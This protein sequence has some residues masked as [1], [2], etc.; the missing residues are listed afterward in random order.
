VKT[1][2][3]GMHPTDFTGRPLQA[4]Q[5]GQAW[6]QFCLV[7]ATSTEEN[8]I[9]ASKSRWVRVAGQA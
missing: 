2:T 9:F 6:L 3:L 4:L 5:R 7:P 1:V 8:F